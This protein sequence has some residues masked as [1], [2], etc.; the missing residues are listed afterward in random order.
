MRSQLTCFVERI[1]L[2]AGAFMRFAGAGSLALLVF[3][4]APAA[5]SEVERLER[6]E[7]LLS[8]ACASCHAIGK[9]GE[10]PNPV[11][12]PFRGLSEDYPVENL[13]ESL[14]EGIMSGHPEMP[15]FAFEPHDV[16][17]IIAYLQSIQVSPEMSPA[18]PQT[19][20]PMDADG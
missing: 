15:V 13:A 1:A 11:A 17:A 19:P 2:R 6:G 20:P 10:S 16:D 5:A 14:A 7:A 4:A 9:T 12:P 8:E 3:A 18:T